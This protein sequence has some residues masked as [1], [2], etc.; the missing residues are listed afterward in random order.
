M[1]SHYAVNYRGSVGFGEDLVKSLCGRVGDL[2]VK[3]VQVS[4]SHS[5]V[6]SCAVYSLTYSRTFVVLRYIL[7]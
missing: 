2:D 6:W 4:T 5:D 1:P 7:R 3:D